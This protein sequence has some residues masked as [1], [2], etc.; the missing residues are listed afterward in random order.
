MV[1]NLLIKKMKDYINLFHDMID[2]ISLLGSLST[3]EKE[4]ILANYL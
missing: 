3:K 2:E 4:K 1:I